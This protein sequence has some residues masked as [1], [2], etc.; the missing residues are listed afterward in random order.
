MKNLKNLKHE[1]EFDTKTLISDI[2]DALKET[3][4]TASDTKEA[5]T[6]KELAQSR[7]ENSEG[8]ETVVYEP[9]PLTPDDD[10][11][12]EILEQF[13]TAPTKP[14]YWFEEFGDYWSCSCGHIN[15]GSSC[16]NCG[17]ERDI[18]RSLFILH[19]PAGEPG[20]LNKK[21]KSAKDKVDQEEKQYADKALKRQQR[22][23]DSNGEL[24]V[25]P[26][27]DDD[28]A[29]D[30][31]QIAATVETK[32]A[33]L[34]KVSADSKSDD[35]SDTP[36]QPIK[37]LPAVVPAPAASPQKP[38][39][40]TKMI[41]AAIILILLI[42]AA[43]AA[44]YVYFAEPAMKYQDAKKL[45]EAGKYEEAIEKYKSLGDYEDCDELIWECYVSIADKLYEDGKY[46]EA[47]DTYEFAMGLKESD[48]LNDKIRDCYIGIGDNYCS[49]KKYK[50]ALS[51]YSTA[52]E[53]KD[54]DKLQEKINAA[55][56][57]FVKAKISDGNEEAVRF[58]NELMDIKYPGIQK[59]YDDYYAWHIKI[60]ANTSEQDYSTDLSTVS[61]KDTVYFHVML[62]GG[63]PS[64]ELQLYYEIS[65]PNGQ[66]QIYDLESTWKDGSKITAGFQYPI[67]LFGKEGELTFKLYDKS[68]Q[69]LLGSDS[70]TFSK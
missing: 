21:L 27:E 1:K 28:C 25:V 18:L 47:I 36:P 14:K 4:S 70:V 68:T 40:R 16:K 10:M 6:L 49:D 34:P 15:K 22:E 43:S 7:A 20:K 23:A 24:R 65:W 26:I 9:R 17:L 63:E 57:G 50:D 38:H 45:Q 54:S 44:I 19:K 2:S 59:I 62:T 29:P 52:K 3:D 66:S 55:K 60:L 39:R 58:M 67:P 11:Y 37:Q 51:A 33:S 12:E 61:R 31:S 41:I 13:A 64:E 35:I 46:S 48:T 53:I 56:F 42:A 69:E 5:V 30:S 32:T 8:R